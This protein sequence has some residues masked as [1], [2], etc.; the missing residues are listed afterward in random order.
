[1][2]RLVFLNLY[3]FLLLYDFDLT[4]YRQMKFSINLHKSQDSPLYILR[5]PVLYL[6]LKA[7]KCITF[8]EDRFCFNKKVHTIWYLLKTKVSLPVKGF[9]S[10]KG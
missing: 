9:R 6:F 2:N 4:L 7:K 5:G 8:S 1:M 10:P 3:I